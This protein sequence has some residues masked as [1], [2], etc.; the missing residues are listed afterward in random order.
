[1]RNKNPRVRRRD[2]VEQEPCVCKLVVK[3]KCPTA[4]L[5][6]LVE[7]VFWM[8]SSSSLQVI[9]YWLFLGAQVPLSRVDILVVVRS[10]YQIQPF[11]NPVTS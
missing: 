4:D 3:E 5:V 9:V 11:V 2:A 8:C 6:G 10:L 1:M 7:G